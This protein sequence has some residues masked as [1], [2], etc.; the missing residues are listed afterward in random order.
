MQVKIK[1]DDKAVG[2]WV[3]QYIA[4]RI[5]DFK[6]TAD[7]PFVLGLATGSTP[8]PTYQALIELHKAGKVS[9]A[10]VVTFNMDEYV[11]LPQSHPESYYSFMWRHLFD[12]ID[13]KKEQVHIL[14]G[15]ASDLAKECADY[16]QKIR[17]FGGMELIIG[18][19]GIDGHIA[20]NEPGSSLTSRT[21]KQPLLHETR[22][23]NS[24]FFDNDISKVPTHALTM[25]V[26]TVT[27]SRE[28][29]LLVTGHNKAEALARIVEGAVSHWWTAS[30]LQMHNHAL[31]LCDESAC[32]RL[33]V[34]TYKY[35]KE[36]DV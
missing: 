23:A 16:E 10:H 5:N 17:D 25:G 28:V 20:F 14:N 9:F 15:N 1:A 13:V 7:R 4:K 26:A 19:I 18:G 21:R 24:R 33:Q 34:A 32:D 30:V 31:I 6:P 8:I 27:D 12:H 36:I 2:T 35:F 29:L 22:V 11:G 3:A